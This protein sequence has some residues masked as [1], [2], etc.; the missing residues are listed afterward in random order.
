MVEPEFTKEIIDHFFRN[1]I[2]EMKYKGKDVMI[3][4]FGS[5]RKKPYLL[6]KAESTKKFQTF[7]DEEKE[8]FLVMKERLSLPNRP[9]KRKKK[10]I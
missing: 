4:N 6:D 8:S 1:A 2:L 3:H 7:S 10:N 5:L 9:D